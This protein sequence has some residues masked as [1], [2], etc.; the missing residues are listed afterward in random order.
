MARKSDDKGL[1]R[2]DFL[3]GSA[4][5]AAALATLPGAGS[6]EEEAAWD[7]EADVVVVGGGRKYRTFRPHPGVW[8]GGNL[9]SWRRSAL[10]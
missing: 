1:S 6:A 7:Q 3:A 9:T 8:G 2:R 5:G 4:V 10:H